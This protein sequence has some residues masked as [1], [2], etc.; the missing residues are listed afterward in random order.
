MDQ[1]WLNFLLEKIPFGGNLGLTLALTL[2]IFLCAFLL[3]KPLNYV[4][5]ICLRKATGRYPLFQQ[6]ILPQVARPIGMMS[7]ALVWLIV[8][9]FMPPLWKSLGGVPLF[10]SKPL[11]GGIKI[12]IK[13]VIGSG[14][15]WISYNLVDELIAL[16]MKKVFKD[17]KQSAGFTTHFLPFINKFMKILV[18]CFGSLLVLQNLGV[19]VVSLLAGLGLGGIAVALA[20]KE[21]A[22]NILAYINIMLDKPFSAGDWICFNDM[23]GTVMEVGLR[24]SKIKT[25][26]DSIITIPNAVLTRANIDNM[27]KRKARRTRIYLG[28]QYNTPTQKIEKFIT[29]IKQILKDNSA[30]KKDYFQVYFTEFGASDLKIIMNFFLLVNEW[31]TELKEKQSIFMAVLNLAEEL[32]ISFA[33]PTR[34]LHINT[35]PALY[36]PKGHFTSTPPSSAP[37][38]ATLADAPIPPSSASATPAPTS[39]PP[40][41]APA[42]ATTLADAP[43]SP[44]SAPASQHNE[45]KNNKD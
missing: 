27:G 36:G 35:P 16:M 21:S 37:A 1:K 8:L 41:S 40:S 2:F 3:H 33:F 30:V 9:N 42:S 23:E 38:S 15:V 43:P 31:E 34:T 5:R 22:S 7:M 12:F 45:I 28:V 18:L 26:Y 17:S 39:T 20:A 10:L 13:I 32:K 4:V 19:N 6:H 11:I 25:F 29:G 44:S 14:L 24:S